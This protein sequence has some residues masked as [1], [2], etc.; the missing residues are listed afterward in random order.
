MN[1]SFT[2]H[3]HDVV[4]DA[5]FKAVFPAPIFRPSF[6]VDGREYSLIWWPRHGWVWRDEEEVNDSTVYERGPW[7][8]DAEAQQDAIAYDLQRR[9]GPVPAKAGQAAGEAV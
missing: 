3:A 8:T 2:E 5:I 7:T 6:W 4:E 1:P 9:K